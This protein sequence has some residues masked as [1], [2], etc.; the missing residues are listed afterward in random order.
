MYESFFGLDQ[1]PFSVAPDP[2]FLYL[3]EQHKKALAHLEYGLQRGGGFVLLTGEIGAGKTTVWRHFLEGLPDNLDVASVV[4]PKLGVQALLARICEDLRIEPASLT[5]GHSDPID[6]LHGHL[7]LAHARGRRTLIVVDEAQ[8][9]S[10]DVMEQLRLLTNLVTGDRKLVQVLLIGQPEL[11]TMLETPALEPL[12][13]RVVA[14]F[15]LP[16]LP[17]EET[18]RYIAHRLSVAG[19]KGVG[20]F[21][22]SAVRR[23]H[24]ICGGVPR[25]INVLCDRALLV[26]KL[27]T[28]KRVDDAVIDRAAVDVFGPPKAPPP[29]PQEPPP[30]PLPPL[31]MPVPAVAPSPPLPAAEPAR[32]GASAFTIVGV[33]GG[34]L[35]VGVVLAMLAMQKSPAALWPA[36]A[37]GVAQVP[38]A[39]VVAPAATVMPAAPVAP[40][41]TLPSQ[42]PPAQPTLTN[43][44]PAPVAAD[45]V[46]QT[47][48]PA[49]TN[50]DTLFAFGASDE[51]AAWRS[52]ADLWGVVLPPGDPCSTGLPQALHCHRGRGGLAPIRQLGRPAVLPL[53][54]ERGRTVH[55]LLVALSEQTATLRGGRAELVV[56]L[57]QLARAWRGDFGTF[58]RAPAGYRP[59]QVVASGSL[60]APWLSERLARVEPPPVAG[61]ASA[62]TL[63]SRVFAF[64]LAQGLL[65]D[66]AA[67]PLTLML[68]NRASGVDEPRLPAVR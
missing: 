66:G 20:L 43:L 1:E 67:G 46:L 68:L 57:A 37:P 5:D 48:Q 11:R 27:I 25:R 3:G 40:T 7:L 58:W 63:E 14:R 32:A 39:A 30:A 33:A 29:P 52:L 24:E 9:L 45:P 19:L 56:P 12:A 38:P 35:A 22:D 16:A 21:D 31:V 6:V 10:I 60:L 65:P 4:N 54:D 15:H 42:T 64:Q 55:V 51:G 8:A 61:A 47:P 36:A 13:Q 17:L 26:A 49:T 28:R 53:V 59:G 41:S 2:R 62:P 18:H 44:P 34:A 50:I 23:I